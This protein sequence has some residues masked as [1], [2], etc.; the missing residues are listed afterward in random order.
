ML[1]RHSGKKFRKLQS[2]PILLLDFL[3]RQKSSFKI[4][5]VEIS[6]PRGIDP[7]WGHYSHPAIS[8]GKLYLRAVMAQ[9]PDGSSGPRGAAAPRRIGPG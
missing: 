9:Q 7:S 3:L 4:P 1:L 5:N 6:R 2:Q 8:G